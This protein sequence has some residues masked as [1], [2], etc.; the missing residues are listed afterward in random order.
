MKI[1]TLIRA[2]AGFARARLLG[3]S[4]AVAVGWDVTHRCNL[5]CRYCGF[6]SEDRRELDTGEA[7]AFA[8]EMAGEGVARVH[9]SGGEPLLRTDLGPIIHQLVSQDVEVAVNTN[10]HLLPR[11]L[12]DLRGVSLIRLSYDGPEEVH[13]ALRGA[14]SH[15]VMRHA[16]DAARGAG[17]RVMFNATINA[18]NVHRV[19]ELLQESRRQG[20]PIKFQPLF[21]HLAMGK[22]LD[23]L[24][25][26]P[27]A[28]DRALRQIRRE[29]RR[30]R[31]VVNS[32]ANLDYYLAGP[33]PPA[34]PCVAGVLYTRADPMGRLYPCSMMRTEKLMRDARALGFSAAFRALP[35]V[36]CRQCLCPP[37][38]ELNA[39][40]ALEWRSLLGLRRY[41]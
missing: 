39:F 31:L 37:T 23:S 6:C 30:S 7:L 11:R 10:G 34:L 38:M 21:D 12:P 17:L 13:D 25:A 22:P 4:R 20:V 8:D 28:L 16:L 29:R 40:Y 5:N 2:G 18:L 14:G 32:L 33:A 26:P 35:R 41:L 15:R 36:H 19:K 3:H 27:A 9:L 1:P 24:A